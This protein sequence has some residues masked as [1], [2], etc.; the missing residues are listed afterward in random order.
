MSYEILLTRPAAKDLE[1]IGLYIAQELHAPQTALYFLEK[2]DCQIK[3]LEEMP[4][5]HELISYEEL[6]HKGIRKVTVQN[7][8]IFYSVDEQ[9]RRVTILRVL[10][11]RRDWENLF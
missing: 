10:Y 5:R 9:A 11:G 2:I 6:A 1:G 8:L 4:H 7:Y 3:N